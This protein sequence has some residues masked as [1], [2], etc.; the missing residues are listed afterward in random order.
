MCGDSSQ[1]NQGAEKRRALYAFVISFVERFARESRK[2]P[3]CLYSSSETALVFLRA[4]KGF[5][6]TSNQAGYAVSAFW[7]KG[8]DSLVGPRLGLRAA[9]PGL[10]AACAGVE[11]AEVASSAQ[12]TRPRGEPRPK[13]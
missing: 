3:V 10:D 7:S 6:Q 1:G 4:A 5:S 12:T 2:K 8:W 11:V 9:P 13:Y